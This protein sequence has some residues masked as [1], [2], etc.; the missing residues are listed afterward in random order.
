MTDRYN[1]FIVILGNDIREDDAQEIINA[2]K[3]IKGVLTVTPHVSG[4]VDLI[5][6]KK[7][8]IKI[9]KKLYS[10]IEDDNDLR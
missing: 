6:E 4:L 1:A 7:A 8:K 10:V 2:I 3:M 5:A 9:L